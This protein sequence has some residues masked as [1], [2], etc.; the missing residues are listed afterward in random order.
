MAWDTAN[1]T[2][3]GWAQNGTPGLQAIELSVGAST[4]TPTGRTFQG[5]DQP[6]GS[7]AGGAD[8]YFDPR[9]PGFLSMVGLHQAAPDSIAIYD[10]ASVYTP[11]P[12]H[13]TCATSA[14]F[15]CGSPPATVSTLAATQDVLPACSAPSVAPGV[16]FRFA[17]TGMP[18]TLST[19]DAATNFDTRLS[20]FTGSCASLVC[21]AD[22][23]DTACG[24]S[25]L[26]SSVSF[27]TTY[28]VAYRVLVHGGK[29]ASDRGTFR[30]SMTCPDYCSA[31]T[32]TPCGPGLEYI[33][34]V[35]MGAIN[36]STPNCAVGGYQNFMQL[37]NPAN[38]GCPQLIVV[39][40]AS[41]VAGDKLSVFIDWN[42][43]LDFADAGETIALVGS[44]LALPNQ[45]TGLITPPPGATLGLTR[46]RVALDDATVM[47]CGVSATAGYQDYSINVL[48]LVDSDGDGTPDCLDGCP[49]DPNKTAPG[50][51]GCGTPDTDSDGDGTPDCI[52]GCPNDPDKIAPGVCDCGTPDTDSDGDGTP[53][54]VDGCPYDP[55]KIAPGFCG[56]GTPETDSDGDG[57]PDCV[58]G[59]PND[60]NKIAPGFCGCNRPETDSDGDGTP[61]CVD[62]CPNDPNKI[63]PGV[64]GCGTPDTDTDGD[65]TPDCIDGCP[66]DPLKTDPLFCGCGNPETDFDGDG[67]PNCIDNCIGVPNPDQLDS[68]GDGRGDLC[69]NCP[70]HINP[71]Q[72]DCDGNGIGNVCEIA[73]GMQP[74]C[75][76]NGIPDNC[77]ADCNF[78]LHPD[79]CDI[80]TGTSLDINFNGVPDECEGPG[81]QFCFGDGTGVPCPCG[82]NSPGPNKGCLNSTGRGALLYNNGSTSVTLDDCRLVAIQLP[83]NKVTIFFVGNQ[84][85]GGGLGLPFSD[86][87][88]CVKAKR[89]YPLQV[90]NGAGII[91]VIGVV[92]LTANLIT[93][94]STWYFQAWY[95][96][97]TGPC[98]TGANF[99]NGLAV[100]FTP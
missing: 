34:R 52:D 64:C 20:V 17:G 19:C 4:L 42:Q 25:P 15:P 83:P 33:T 70:L 81:T 41:P 49:G 40:T 29:L 96:D 1:N 98:L 14:F 21:V 68:D 30:L 65:G 74:D 90:S 47:A 59:C 87:L 60:P 94:G 53:D 32:S 79:D 3:W 24:L 22:N 84:T 73:T 12:Y 88:L 7:T 54:C 48:A 8:I 72:L 85:H 55:N 31:G 26:S 100:T 66:N 89:R 38:I 99:T 46:M 97:P 86:G 39:D 5:Q 67:V 58:D 45:F 37:V 76:L 82:N 57:T 71:N 62:G 50:V 78:N 36:N 95:R 35:Q 51:C 18:I 9:N 16:W 11:A 91:D 69:D 28:G 13:D 63:A 27:P 43:D 23:D 61:N 77:D 6:L 92:T 75:N 44:P 2:L 93:P 80:S 56:C 10:I